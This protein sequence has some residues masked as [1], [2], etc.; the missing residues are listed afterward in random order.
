MDSK[1]DHGVKNQISITSTSNAVIDYFNF[2]IHAV[3]VHSFVTFIWVKRFYVL[4]D[5]LL[6][7]DSVMGYLNLTTLTIVGVVYV[8]I[9]V[10]N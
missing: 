9:S 1:S 2:G 4:K 5:A 10:N 3:I 8:V 7:N 6:K